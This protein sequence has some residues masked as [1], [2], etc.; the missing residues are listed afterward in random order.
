MRRKWGRWPP[1][2]RSWGLRLSASRG[3]RS[4][5][6]AAFRPRTS[7]GFGRSRGFVSRPARNKPSVPG[8][9]YSSRPRMS[10]SRARRTPRLPR[11]YFFLALL[12]IA[13]FAAVQSFVYLDRYLREPLM[14]LAKER[15]TEMAVQAIN[16]AITENIAAGADGSKMVHWK[17]NAAGK[18]TG[19]EI[20]Y[21]EQMRITAQTI[22]VVEEALKE[23]EALHERIPIGH[24][25]DSPFLSSLGPSVA[26]R[27]HP[28]STVQAEVRT[29]QTS[30]G[31]NNVLVEVYI[32]V[33]TNIAIVIPFDRE[34]NR[35]ETDI[36]LSYVMV[37][38]DT[39][40]YYYDGGGNPVG[41]GASQAPALS[42]PAPS[43]TAGP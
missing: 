37:A 41:S 20:D 32:H 13:L 24:A 17:T 23:Q 12:A 8:R 33:A 9:A 4:A 25:V 16:A 26:V 31:I 28:I 27:L 11:R 36:P 40:L 10:G 35:I 14:F 43:A 19:I 22:A 39:P 15:I 21:K 3:W 30:A 7:S 42:L 6:S 2:G 18:T 34:P 1:A 5:R 38:G 29:R